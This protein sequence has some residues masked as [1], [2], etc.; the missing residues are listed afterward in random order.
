MSLF[1]LVLTLKLKKK[2]K[3]ILNIILHFTSYTISSIKL[4]LNTLPVKKQVRNTN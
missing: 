3:I 1:N 4:L 2:Q